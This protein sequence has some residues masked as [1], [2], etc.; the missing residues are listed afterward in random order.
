M[1]EPYRLIIADDEA[2]IREGMASYDWERLG[3]TVAGTASTGKKALDLMEKNPADLI[4]TDIRM[5]VMDGLELSGILK[6]KYP[7]CKIVILTGYK[8]FDYAKIAIN[9]GV[10]EYILKPVDLKKYEGLFLK[11]RALLE[12]EITASQRIRTY[13][14]RL[15]ESI[16]VTIENFL[17]N[18]LDRKITDVLEIDEKMNLLEIYMNRSY[19]ACAI[20]QF[21]R[22][23]EL[24][25]ADSKHA[26]IS[27]I[28][29]MIKQRFESDTLGYVLSSSAQELILLFNFDLPGFFKSSYDFLSQI[30]AGIKSEIMKLGGPDYTISFTI[31][32]GNLYSSLLSLPLSYEEAKE[33]LKRKFFDESNDTF[34]AWNYKS[35][36]AK[37]IGE[38]PYEKENLLLNA[39][40]NGDTEQSITALDL[41]WE[42]LTIASKRTDPLNFK[43]LILQMLTVLEHRLIKHGTSLEKTMQITPPYSN[44]IDAFITI[45]ELKSGIE[46]MIIS[47]SMAVNEINNSVKSTS[48]S[49]IQRAL[50]YIDKHYSEK[51]ALN[52]IAEKVYLSP[53]Y[54]SAQFKRETGKTFVEYIKELRIQ[55]A[56]ELLKQIDLK[57]YEISEAVGYQNPRYFADTFRE[58]TGMTPMEYR[59]KVIS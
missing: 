35:I 1:N 8:D 4:I 25:T 31:G 21:A 11:I 57:I 12:D 16:P 9:L 34:F 55:K 18:I 5:P 2:I 28:Y 48:Y 32:A 38:Y 29:S 17:K 6:E 33:A 24:N 45:T 22:V 37:T 14:M 42:E 36:L 23:Q 30:I 13:E 54:F 40:M 49:A 52:D 47:V 27:A 15:K 50:A 53:C 3:F 51:I 44:Y 26:S 43:H 10:S 19:Y 46:H 56:K 39:V 20:L 58:Y 59:Q 7:R 41:F